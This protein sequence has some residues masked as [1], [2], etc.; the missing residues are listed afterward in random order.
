MPR[1]SRWSVDVPLVSLPTFVLGNYAADLPDTPAYLD[2]E[3]PHDLCIS[4][5]DF[6][7]WSKRLAAGLREAGL[8]R[9]ER[10]F[11]LSGNNIF[12]PVVFMG[13]IMAGGIITTANPA[14]V[15]REVAYQLKDSNPRFFLV[16]ETALGAAISAAKDIGFN[17]ANMF[18]FDEAPLT[19]Q[20]GQ[21]RGAIRH[22]QLLISGTQAGEEF[23]WDERNTVE[24]CQE[25]VAILYSSGTT[26]VPK[27]VEISHYHLVANACQIDYVDNLDPRFARHQT[28]HHLLCALPMYHGLGLLMYATVAP[29]RRSPVY[30]MK[31]YT[32]PKLL[33][34]IHR[35]RITELTLVPPIILAMVK[36]AEL[37]Q[38]KH[39]VSSVRRITTG[40]APITRE[41]CEELE[42]LWPRGDLNVK[43]A[44]GMTE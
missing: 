21:P 34:A 23:S 32:L 19:P 25:T 43:Q 15:S 4:F 27:G 29:Y 44:W 12:F 41:T 39:D 37:R 9:Q 3:A 42:K 22:W 33:K 17:C 24:A 20:G 14:F 13:V 38:G 6:A 40:A 11:V 16:A 35:N 28:S 10:V 7:L 26:G 18:V 36:S 5:S 30:I 1:K 31:R 2:A 8:R